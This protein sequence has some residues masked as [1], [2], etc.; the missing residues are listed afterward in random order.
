MFWQCANLLGGT[1]WSLA[2]REVERIGCRL[3]VFEGPKHTVFAGFSTVPLID[4]ARIIDTPTE[5]RFV[6]MLAAEIAVFQQR[7]SI[8][9]AVGK[10]FFH[11]PLPPISRTNVERQQEFE[12]PVRMTPNTLAALPIVMGSNAC[13]EAR[14]DRGL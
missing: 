6:G 3:Y 10:L 14:I 4:E 12:T 2:T 13:R 11:P 5:V 9:S 7:E 1:D 8:Y